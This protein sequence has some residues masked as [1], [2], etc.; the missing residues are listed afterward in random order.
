MFQIL[1]AAKRFLFSIGAA[2][3]LI[4]TMASCAGGGGFS[5]E[6]IRYKMTV[7]VETPEG[8]KTGSAVRE[9]SRYTEPS[10]LPDQGGT[11]YN[12]TKGEAV[13]VDL[14]H[15]G[16]LFVLLGGGAEAKNVFKSLA[17]DNDSRVVELLPAQYPKIVNF[18][19]RNDPKTI[20][21]VLETEPCADPKTGIPHSTSCV[22]NDRFGEIY[23]EGVRLKSVNVE[24]TEEQVTR[25]VE[26]LMP[27]YRDQSS[28]MQWFRTLPYG[29]PRTVNA[30]DFGSMGG[31]K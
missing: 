20:E 9:A 1:C 29:D 28:Y 5:N 8:I 7:T 26:K 25:H 13:V 3:A 6:T 31:A 15:R 21:L 24:R 30:N 22:K 27:S 16:V 19:D 11:F 2:S 4:F 18:K 12:I 14:G 17:Q 10:I 23:G